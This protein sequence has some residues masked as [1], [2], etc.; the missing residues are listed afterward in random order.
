MRRGKTRT[1]GGM[2]FHLAPH[3]I[4]GWLYLVPVFF[5]A[6]IWFIY[7]FVAMP[8]NQTVW[9][10]ASSQLEQTF[11]NTNSHAWWFAWMVA[12]PMACMLLAL[13]YL[14]KVPRTRRGRITLF[15]IAIALAITTFLLNDWSVGVWVALPALWG[16]RAI[17]A[18]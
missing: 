7:L 12:L 16:Y 15:V 17:H 14:R 2:R 11:S 18:T 1:L 3:A 9:Q 6:G 4:A 8:D 5:V 13:A 10:S